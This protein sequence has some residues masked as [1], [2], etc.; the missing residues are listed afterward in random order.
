[1]KNRFA[2]RLVASLLLAGLLASPFSLARADEGDD[3]YKLALGLYKDESWTLAETAFQN[4][5]TKHKDHPRSPLARLYLGQAQVQL[6]KYGAARSTLQDFVK[7][8]PTSRDVPHAEYRIAECSYFLGKLEDAAKGF[9]AFTKDHEKDPLNEMAW[10]YLGDSQRRLKQYD[11]AA[12]SLTKSLDLFPKGRMADEARFGL[13]QSTEKLGKI[14]EAIALF[15]EVAADET[16]QRAAEAQLQIGT[17]LFREKK[18]EDA[19][20]EYQKL[21]ERFPDSTLVSTAWLNSGFSLYE[22]GEF[23]K[24]MAAFDKAES[25]FESR[26]KDRSQFITAGYWKGLCLK[27]LEAYED[28]AE[29]LATVAKSGSDDPLAESILYQ[30]AD[31]TF[32]AGNLQ[33]AEQRFLVVTS[34][35]PKGRYGDH[36]LYFATECA[37]ELATEQSGEDRRKHIQ[38]A[39]LLLDKFERDYEKSTIRFSHDMQRGHFLVLRDEPGDL[40]AAEELYNRIISR[41]QRSQTRGEAR[42]E[43]AR[44]LKN[45]GDTKAALAMITP[46]AR[47]V[48]GDAKVGFPE[49]LILYSHLALAEGDFG[50]VRDAADNYLKANAAGVNRDQAWAYLAM[51]SARAKDWQEADRAIGQLLSDHAASPIVSRTINSVAETAY[52]GKTWEEAIRF[53]TILSKTGEESPFFPVAQ[54]G[55]GWSHFNNGNFEA[56]ATHFGIVVEKTPKHETAPEAGFKIGECLL[57]SSKKEEAAKAFEA[58]FA[59]FQPARR[60]FLAGVQAA[61]VYVNVAD[62]KSADAVYSAVDKAFPEITEHDL[63]LNEWA[64]LR[65]EAEDYD[66]SDDLFARLVKEHPDSGFADNARF[67]LAESDLVNGKEK[68]AAEQFAALAA[69]KKADAD[70]QTDSLYRLVGIA[71]GDEDWKS[72]VARAGELNQRFEKNRYRLEMLFQSGNAQLNLALF[73]KA[74][75]TL[76]LVVAERK[77]PEAAQSDWLPHAWVLL[78]E[79]Q[80]RQ[81]S[82]PKKATEAL[83]TAKDFRDQNPRSPL[84]YRI[85]EIAGRAYMRQAKFDDARA[86]FKRTVDSKEGTRTQTAAKAQFMI[87]ESYTTQKKYREAREAYSRVYLLYK[88][89]EWR[90]P[91][92]YQMG[93]CDQALGDKPQAIATFEKFLEEFPESTH[94]A[95]V[96]KRLGT[97]KGTK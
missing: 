94:E 97:L 74:E 3:D 62:V 25:G 12:A 31:C 42:F 85:D 73:T 65:Y 11:K 39:G 70:V 56:A 22:L 71:A 53:F 95:D 34:R 78:A 38:T 43:L 41:S 45:K 48:M 14:P 90:E 87:G 69:D 4:F 57:Q 52:D 82:D 60:A 79:S 46:L 36:S 29:V 83:A 24:A 32:R 84:T 18:F 33:Q 63:V 67:S 75:A 15:R 93:V 13:A 28:A 81:K 77:S 72:V 27:A 89:P 40:K 16:S 6:K 68:E 51:A 54:S 9:A 30:L 35:W 44:L 10:A 2:Y 17:L 96:K 86:A 80:V 55:L 92:R 23:Q 26:P 5:L 47:E 64:L 91:A 66:G 88:H 61:R 59:K 19:T 49:A 76:K 58:A 7:K 8:H 20:A 1:M 37:L 50:A 21:P